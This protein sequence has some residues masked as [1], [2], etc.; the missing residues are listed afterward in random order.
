M[1]RSSPHLSPATNQCVC[2]LSPSLQ[3]PIRYGE[4]APGAVENFAMIAKGDTV[5][6]VS[7]K[8]SAFHRVI[9]NFM[10]QVGGRGGQ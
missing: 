9:E 1:P 2:L 7:Y 4:V 5:G 8:G 3:P 6:K 10:I